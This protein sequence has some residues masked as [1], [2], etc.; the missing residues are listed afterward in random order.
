MNKSLVFLIVLTALVVALVAPALAP[1]P[2][3][4]SGPVCPAPG[5]G[6]AGALNM[7][8]DPTMDHTMEYHTA[9]QGNAGMFRAVANTACPPP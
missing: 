1:V 4:A 7:V 6:Y 8:A 5:T 9:P 3:E 2:A